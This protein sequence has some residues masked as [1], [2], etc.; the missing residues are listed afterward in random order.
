MIPTLGLLIGAYCTVKMIDLIADKSK[1]G[2]V[3]AFAS[4]AIVVIVICVLSLLSTG[5]T[6][7]LTK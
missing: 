4:V 3:K 2:I 6:T 5:M 7:G 1:R